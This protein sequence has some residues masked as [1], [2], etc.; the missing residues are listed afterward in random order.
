MAFKWKT[1]R[2]GLC[3]ETSSPE[4]KRIIFLFL[5]LAVSL[6]HTNIFNHNCSF[7][8]ANSFNFICR[9][10]IYYRTTAAAVS[11]LTMFVEFDINDFNVSSLS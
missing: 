4:N 2:I 11:R 7:F 6:D 8:N 9:F 10:S 3:F 5:L 1:H